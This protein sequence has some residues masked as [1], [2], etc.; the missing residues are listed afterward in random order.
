MRIMTTLCLI[1]VS[2]SACLRSSADIS[3][4]SGVNEKT[5]PEA[6]PS[7]EVT[8]LEHLDCLLN[9]SC[10]EGVCTYRGDAFTRKE[11]DDASLASDIEV[12]DCQGGAGCS[13]SVEEMDQDVPI[14]PD[15]GPGATIVDAMVPLCTPRASTVC[16]E[17]DIYWVDSCGTRG[18]L[19]VDCQDDPDAREGSVCLGDPPT[20]GCIPE[21]STACVNGDAYWIDSCG[22]AGDLI[23]RCQG[24]L[25]CEAGECVERVRGSGSC[26]DPIEVRGTY[27]FTVNTCQGEDQSSYCGSEGVTELVMRVVSDQ[28]CRVQLLSENAT[29]KITGGSCS[30]NGSCI[31]D[32][33]QFS[34]NVSSANLVVMERSPCGEI[35]IDVSCD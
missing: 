31:I 13:S 1:G 6:K 2:L 22:E 8:C 24:E 3:Q 9:Q 7:A 35:I 21:V 34:S 10:V 23:A 33:E 27:V 16:Y 4:G 11:V 30:G 19:S 5:T 25:V 17:E 18:A 14:G 20:C 32:V 12:S 29:Y 15:Q 28:T 26:Q